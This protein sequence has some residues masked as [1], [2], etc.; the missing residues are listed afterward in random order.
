MVL[1]ASVRNF[2]L[3]SIDSSTR[4]ERTSYF[5]LPPR[6]DFWRILKT[7]AASNTEGEYRMGAIGSAV[8]IR[9]S[10]HTRLAE[11]RSRT[12]EVFAIVRDEAM[13]DRPSAERHR[14]IF[15]TGHG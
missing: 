15:Y 2:A 9:H 14:I 8:R 1:S 13:Y 10:L 11:A 12:D 5:A 4:R 7:E 3:I 6:A